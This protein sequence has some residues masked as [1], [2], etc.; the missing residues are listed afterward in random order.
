MNAFE[1]NVGSG[2]R[3]FCAEIEHCGIVADALHARLV[4]Q[5]YR[6]CQV[7]YQA[8]FAQRFECCFGIFVVHCKVCSNFDDKISDF[9]AK[10]LHFWLKMAKNE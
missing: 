2:K 6:F 4:G 5:F 1:Q 9:C 3:A 7:L 10:W 8:K